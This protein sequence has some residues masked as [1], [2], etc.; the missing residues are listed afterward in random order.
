MCKQKPLQYCQDIPPFSPGIGM[1]LQ[2]GCRAACV[3]A[4]QEQQ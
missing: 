1:Q 2:L 4:Q 3:V